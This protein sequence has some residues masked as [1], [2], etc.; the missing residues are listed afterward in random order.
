MVVSPEVEE[1]WSFLCK[2]T[3]CWAFLFIFFP[4]PKNE[5][6][7]NMKE[8]LFQIWALYPQESVYITISKKASRAQIIHIQEKKTHKQNHTTLHFY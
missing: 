7:K 8:N 1:E 4:I 2:K 3:K 5:A 6:K